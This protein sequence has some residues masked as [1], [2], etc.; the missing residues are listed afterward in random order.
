M[1]QRSITLA[2]ARTAV[3]ACETVASA[4]T[5]LL[6]ELAEEIREVGASGTPTENVIENIASVIQSA[7]SDFGSLIDGI[8]DTEHA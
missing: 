2:E 1:S 6:H 8:A 5:T 3:A 7:G 4:V